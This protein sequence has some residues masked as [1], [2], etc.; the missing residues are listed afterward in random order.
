MSAD[1]VQAAEKCTPFDRRLGHVIRTI[2]EGRGLTQRDLAE[3]SGISLRT[4]T[5][6]ESGRCG[7]VAI[8]TIERVLAALDLS[9]QIMGDGTVPVLTAESTLEEKLEVVRSVWGDQE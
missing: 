3:A 4:V 8:S 1:Y 9:L 5:T 2:R 6:I 7:G